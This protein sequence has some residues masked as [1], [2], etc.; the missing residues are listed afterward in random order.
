MSSQRR[1]KHFLDPLLILHRAQLVSALALL[2]SESV[3]QT[4]DHKVLP[5]KSAIGTIL[6]TISELF[7]KIEFSYPLV[8]S[9]DSLAAP[10]ASWVSLQVETKE[11]RSNLEQV[12]SNLYA[13]IKAK[14]GGRYDEDFLESTCGWYF[15]V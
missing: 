4:L 14:Y 7:G 1:K 6:N 13:A 10:I 12:V 5:I 3:E 8:I 2:Q 9:I 15:C 11:F